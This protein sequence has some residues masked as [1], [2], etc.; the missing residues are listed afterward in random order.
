MASER[1]PPWRKTGNK[2]D[3][4]H[5]EGLGIGSLVEFSAY[6]D[7]NRQQGRVLGAITGAAMETYISGGR[8]FEGQVLAI[9]DGYYQYWFE[10]LYGKLGDSPITFFHFC[11]VPVGV[12][13][14]QTAFRNPIHMDVFRLVN[15]N[16]AERLAWLNDSQKARHT[17][18]LSVGRTHLEVGGLLLLGMSNLLSDQVRKLK[19]DCQVLKDWPGHWGL[20]SPP[21]SVLLTRPAKRR[22]RR[23]RRKRIIKEMMETE[24]G[25]AVTRVREGGPG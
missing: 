3:P 16:Q 22:R 15:S 11:D 8:V 19:Q 2:A 6:D 4:R 21:T 9:E 5:F 7:R 17:R 10:E 14:S 13:K 25:L 1:L 24:P 12:C 18:W 23:S 20:V